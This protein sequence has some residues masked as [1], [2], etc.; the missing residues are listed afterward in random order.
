MTL[1]PVHPDR[2]PLTPE[3]LRDLLL[4]L[5]SA[6]DRVEHIRVIERAGMLWIGAYV[7]VADNDRAQESLHQ[8]C[9][10]LAGLINGWEFVREPE[11]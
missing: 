8:L 4:G 10:R 9:D 11:L 1:V 3:S 2:T 7:P 5:R 6:E